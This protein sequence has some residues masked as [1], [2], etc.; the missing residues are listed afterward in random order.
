MYTS[1]TLRL[2]A[3]AL[4]AHRL[5]RSRSRRTSKE[6]GPVFSQANGTTCAGCPYAIH[7]GSATRDLLCR[8]VA[9]RSSPNHRRLVVLDGFQKEA[10]KA[11]LRLRNG[12][13]VYTR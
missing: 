10:S 11:G 13:E 3:H 4:G 1:R 5:V 6:W 12:D 8:D 9:P 2:P 7:T